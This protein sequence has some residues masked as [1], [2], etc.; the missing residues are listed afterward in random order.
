MPLKL[1]ILHEHD[2]QGLKRDEAYGLRDELQKMGHEVTLVNV[3]KAKIVGEHIE[4]EGKT[5]NPSDFDG[6]T[7]RASARRFGDLARVLERNG[8][9]IYQDVDLTIAGGDKIASQQIFERHNIPTPKTFCLPHNTPYNQPA[10]NQFLYALGDSTYV[11]KQAL[12]WSGKQVSI[13]HDKSNV[14]DLFRQ[15]HE[16]SAQ[17]KKGGVLVQ[18]FI[19]S[20]PERRRDYRVQTVVGVN[21]KGELESKV[22]AAIVRIAQH[23]ERITNVSRGAD[24]VRVALDE[25]EA[26]EHHVTKGKMPPDEFKRKVEAGEIHILPP[27]VRDVANQ[28]G[29]AFGTGMWGHDIIVDLQ[30]GK[31]KALEVNPF[32]DNSTYESLHGFS[33]HKPWAEAFAGYVAHQKHSKELSVKPK[34]RIVLASQSPVKLEALNKALLA[35]NIY[36]EVVGVAAESGVPAQPMNEQTLQG[37][38]NR[39]THAR[40]IVH[41]ADLYVAI[42]NGLFE[43]EGRFFDKAAILTETKDGSQRTT[44]SKSIECPAEYVEEAR[45]RGFDTTTVVQSWQRKKAQSDPTFADAA[46]DFRLTQLADALS[47]NLGGALGWTGERSQPTSFASRLA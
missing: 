2:K 21:G 20:N 11:V 13:Q 32:A 35:K 19:E 45:R 37:A 41:D 26:F 42:E 1:L 44:Y 14:R 29:K 39:L 5:I 25:Q 30:E 15:W 27:D 28:M 46:R 47:E 31:A 33:L 40:H 16:Q 8:V 4:C 12:G 17:E 6:A 36:A 38:K 22:V 34:L 10:L 18:E 9:S 23:G 3:G 7:L 43:E 24:E